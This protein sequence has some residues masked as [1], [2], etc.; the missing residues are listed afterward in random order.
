MPVLDVH[1]ACRLHRREALQA[2]PLQSDSEFVDVEL[3]AK[4]TFLG[5]LIDEVPVPDLPTDQERRTALWRHDAHDVFRHPTFKKTPKS[6][7]AEHPQGEEESDDG[8]G[9]E[10]GQGDRQSGDPGALQENHSQAVAELGQRQGGDEG[11]HGRRD[12]GGGEEDAGEHPHGEHDEVHQPADGLDGLGAAATSRPIPA[13]DMAP[14]T[15]T[16]MRSKMLP[17]TGI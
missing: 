10:N 7:P 6:G 15:S 3:L 17:R 4:A 13:K 9:R 1:S 8:P 2:V 5:H 16:S 11:L 12:S 14:R